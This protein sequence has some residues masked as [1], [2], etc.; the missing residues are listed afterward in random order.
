MELFRSGW[1]CLI[2]AVQ[3]SVSEYLL[4][5]VMALIQVQVFCVES[6]HEVFHRFF[7]MFKALSG[8]LRQ[9]IQVSLHV[10]FRISSDLNQSSCEFPNIYW[11]EPLVLMVEKLKSTFNHCPT[12]ITI[13][14]SLVGII[15]LFILAWHLTLPFLPDEDHGIVPSTA[16]VALVIDGPSCAACNFRVG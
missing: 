1:K 14:R 6:Y 5:Q 8:Q 4:P 15:I 3:E 9:Q 11:L 16:H 7:I 12:R 13:F 10:P 2:L